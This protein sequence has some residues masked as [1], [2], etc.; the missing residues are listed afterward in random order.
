MG[1]LNRIQQSLQHGWN[2][3]NDPDSVRT[4]H[5]H[6]ETSY[7]R[8]D[9]PRL[10]GGNERSIIT[11]VYNRIAID[12]AAIDIKH[13]KLDENERYKET[14]KSGLNNCLTVEANLDQSARAFKHDIYL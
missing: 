7:R 4:Y 3:F 8:P 5:Y 9:R 11:S 10:S 6:G 13:V 14:I 12:A 1:L 2:A